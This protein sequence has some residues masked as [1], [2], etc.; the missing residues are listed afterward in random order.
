M[1][2][3]IE[4]PGRNPLNLYHL[5]SDLNGTL[6]LDGALLEGVASRMAQLARHFE[7][8]LL[9]AD[10]YGTLDTVMQELATACA[11]VRTPA[12]GYAHVAS[13]VEK[14]R[15]VQRLGAERVVVLGNGAN[16]VRMFDAAALSIGILGPEGSFGK[17]LQSAD[18]V[19][20]SVLDALDLFLH[21][22][23]LIAT[24]RL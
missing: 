14:E 5:V 12:P 15:Y 7:I 24:L 9:T 17:A 10:T 19:V 6:A 2:L 18:I 4:I 22:R 23:R 21:P 11:A 16:D 3:R 1:P 8:H 13:G 20:T